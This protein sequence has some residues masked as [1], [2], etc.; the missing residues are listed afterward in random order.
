MRLGSGKGKGKHTDETDLNTTVFPHESYY[1]RI[2]EDHPIVN[3]SCTAEPV[4]HLSFQE[5]VDHA[6][7]QSSPKDVKSLQHH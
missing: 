3:I 5:L 1:V 6:Q 7:N 2:A 4:S